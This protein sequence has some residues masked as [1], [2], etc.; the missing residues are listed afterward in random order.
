MLM[1]EGC[2]SEG[3][4]NHLKNEYKINGKIDC[5]PTTSSKAADLIDSHIEVGGNNNNKTQKSTGNDNDEEQIAGIHAPDAPDDESLDND[6]LE[7]KE[8]PTNELMIAALAAVQD[9]GQEDHNYYTPLDTDD[10]DFDIDFETEEVAGIHVAV[11]IQEES[12]D[13]SSS[14]SS[15][16]HLSDHYYC[17]SDDNVYSTSSDDGESSNGSSMPGLRARA[18]GFS[19]S[20]DED[21]KV[22]SKNDDDNDDNDSIQGSMMDKNDEVIPSHNA[23]RVALDGRVERHALMGFR[24]DAFSYDVNI[25]PPLTAPSTVIPPVSCIIIPNDQ[26]DVNSSVAAPIIERV[27]PAG[28]VPIRV[29]RDSFRHVD[30]IIHDKPTLLNI[31]GETVHN[32]T[33]FTESRRSFPTQVIVNQRIVLDTGATLAIPNLPNAFLWQFQPRRAG[34]IRGRGSIDPPD[35]QQ[36]EN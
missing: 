17:P 18:A 32:W 33:Q 8:S 30:D 5:Y 34:V 35:F 29:Q 6:C 13:E 31:A 2:D 3:L 19:S 36:G 16:Y 15:S 25:P 27:D 12:E 23:F 21:S 7:G 11:E 4:K 26:G 28:R 24:Q 20:D 9:G 22:S 14:E 1:I 10:I